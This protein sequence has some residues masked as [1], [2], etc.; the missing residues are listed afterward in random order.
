VNPVL[1]RFDGAIV[2]VSEELRRYMLE[3]RFPAARVAVIRN[4]I[5][6]GPRPSP[7]DRHAARRA[8]G[9]AAETFVAVSVARLDPVKD[10]GT[11]LDAFATVRRRAA[12]AR[13]LIVGDGPERAAIAARA[14][15]PDLDG[16]VHLIGFR[17]DVR[18][19]IAAA[20]VYVNS[21]ISEGISITILEAMAAG[22]PVVATAVGGTPEVLANGAGGL[23]VPSR[24]AERLASAILALAADPQRRAVLGAA[25]RRRLETSFTIDRMVDEYVATYRGLLG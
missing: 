10:F 8:L 7:A 1:S 5:E 20:D 2:A 21:S 12:G 4:G 25:G 9:I 17:S 3:A 11:L 18:A 23:L 6:A 15:Q 13:L 14:A 19:L 16:A 24:D 22:L